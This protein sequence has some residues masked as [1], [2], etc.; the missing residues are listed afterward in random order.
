MGPYSTKSLADYSGA[1][2][3]VGPANPRRHPNSVISAFA[4]G[5]R[6]EPPRTVVSAEWGASARIGARRA[7]GREKMPFQGEGGSKCRASPCSMRGGDRRR[8]RQ[9]GN[10][11][12]AFVSWAISLFTGAAFDLRPPGDGREGATNIVDCVPDRISDRAPSGHC[13]P[14]RLGHVPWTF[15]PI[16]S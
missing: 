4:P 7:F 13:G 8:V 5:R 12:A 10:R 9:G 1:R 16:G 11:G 2:A 6:V 3:R 15:A 14:P